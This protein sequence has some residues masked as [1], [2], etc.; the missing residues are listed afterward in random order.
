MATSGVGTIITGGTATDGFDQGTTNASLYTYDVANR[1]YVAYNTANG[2]NTKQTPLKAGVGYY[3]F[4]Y[5]DRINSITSSSPNPTTLRQ[6]G[7]LLT[8]TQTYNT[9]SAIPISGTVGNYSLIGNPYACTIDWKSVAKTNVSKTIWG[10][11]A[12]LSSTGGYVTVTATALGALVSPSSNVI[13]VNRYVQPGQAFFVQTTAANPQ[14]LIT[15]ADKID[16]KANINSAVFRGEGVNEQPLMAI[17]LLYNNGFTTSLL[18]GA[19]VAYDASFNNEVN[20]DDALKMTGSTEALAIQEGTSLLS[21][22]ARQFPVVNDTL[23]ISLAKITKSQYTLQIF[24]KEMGASYLEP[25]LYDAFLNKMQALSIID[26]NYINFTVKSSDAGSYSANRFSIVF[27]NYVTLPVTFA[28]I[29]AVRKNNDAEVQ[30]NVATESNLAVYELQRSADGLN[31]KTIATISPKGNNSS[32]QGYVQTDNNTLSGNNYYRVK[33]VDTDGKQ[34]LSKVVMVTMNKATPMVKVFPNPVKDYRIVLQLS[35]LDR[36]T[37]NLQLIHMNGRKVA[38]RQ[39]EYPGGSG[40]Y[41]M[42]LDKNLSKGLYM[43]RITGTKDTFN[44]PVLIQ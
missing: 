1:R 41:E 7:T 2:K 10:W 5:G 16:D 42:Q 36:G 24:A 39:I 31:F 23:K 19:L 21:I 3:M 13:A 28:N 11:D 8:G 25:W 22:S 26:T 12:N 43:L 32:A 33:S 4:V 40:L 38:E 27:K 35:D 20:Y 37:Y 29:T 34:T 15:E 14:V 44:Q 30:W 6:T 18:D 17:N 9:A